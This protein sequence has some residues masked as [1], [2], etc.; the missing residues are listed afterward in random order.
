MDNSKFQFAFGNVFCLLC[1]MAV[2]SLGLWSHHT[3]V[4]EGKL[5]KFIVSEY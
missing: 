4:P 2:K 3:S 1:F 5:D